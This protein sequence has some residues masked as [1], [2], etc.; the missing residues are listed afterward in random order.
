MKNRKNEI[1]KG[2]IGVL[3]NF[4]ITLFILSK[5]VYATSTTSNT[6]AENAAKWILDGLF[7][8]VAIAAVFG[9]AMSVIKRQLIAAVSIFVASALVLVVINDPTVLTT[10]GT[11]LRTI[12]GI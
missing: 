1:L 10:V 4:V 11:T 3:S 8:V 12:L 9:I 6:Y 5:S 7:W 2:I